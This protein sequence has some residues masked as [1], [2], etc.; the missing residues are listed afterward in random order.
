MHPVPLHRRY[1]QP[2]RI[3]LQPVPLSQRIAL[4]ADQHQQMIC[5]DGCNL[6]RGHRDIVYFTSTL[7]CGQ[8]FQFTVEHACHAAAAIQI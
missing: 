2:F 7:I 4:P 1:S 6:L 8:Q 5:T 3:I